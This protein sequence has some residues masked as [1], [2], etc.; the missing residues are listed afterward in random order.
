MK[1][2][3]ATGPSKNP[4]DS[5]RSVVQVDELP[6]P[7]TTG[8]EHTRVIALLNQKGGV[9]KTTST[10]NLGAAFALAGLRTLVVDLDPQS[11][12]SLHF[13]HEP[14]AD[15][16]TVRDLFMNPDL[17]SSEMIRV[18]RENLW[19]IPSDTELALVEGE[20]ALQPNMQHIL[21]ERLAPVM[22]SFDVVLL[23]CPPSL[24]VLTVNALTI[25][26][27]VIVPTQ[28]QY[29]ALRGLEKQ[30]ETVLLVQRALNPRL[31]VA[32]VLLCM[33]ES[34]S[35]H[36]KAVVEEMDSYFAKYRGSE[37]PWQNAEVLRPAVRRNIKL[38]EAPSFGQTIFDYAPTC[39]GAADYRALAEAIRRRWKP[40]ESRESEHTSA[41]IATS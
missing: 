10:A 31:T 38:A 22:S 1:R 33:H 41:G 3:N 15:Q 12:L 28:A 32:G 23:D 20:L 5:P 6:A 16:P 35:S 30:L 26:D 21:A 29:L 27:E 4:G 19:F 39:A 2:E 25:A 40:L 14:A 7:S 37:L 34:Q 11:N 8:M 18:A 9:G 17:A 36:G 24:G 13:G